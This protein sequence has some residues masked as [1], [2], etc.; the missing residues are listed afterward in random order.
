MKKIF[1]LGIIACSLLASDAVAQ[2]IY[3]FPSDEI[4][5][6]TQ[7]FNVLCMSRNGRYMGGMIPADWV[8]LYDNVTDKSII[9]DETYGAVGDGQGNSILGISD[10]G[11]GVG[12]DADG[13]IMCDMEGN[14]KLLDTGGKNYVFASANDITSDGNIAVGA[15]GT[16]W[17][18]IVPCYWE[19]GEMVLLPWP[20]TAQFGGLTGNQKISGCEARKVSADGSVIVGRFVA[21]PNTYPMIVWERQPDGTYEYV[22]VWDDMYEPTHEMVYDYE[23]GG[24]HLERG[25]NPYCWFQPLCISPDGTTIAMKI[26][27][28]TEQQNPPTVLGYY[29][30]P[31]RTLTLPTYSDGN[32]W[33]RYGDVDA[34]AMANDKTVV[35]MAGSV[36]FGDASPVVQKYGEAPQTLISLYPTLDLLVDYQTWANN[37]Y[38]YIVSGISADSNTLCG[39]SCQV[40]TFTNPG[41]TGESFTDLAYF[42][43]YI[44]NSPR[45]NGVDG[46][47]SD[48]NEFD[49]A[50]CEYYTLDG[51]RVANPDRGIY[52]QRSANGKARKVVL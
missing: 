52:I 27:R 51:R 31:T 25:D 12:F 46:V 41:G 4:V 44:E 14:Y 38:P 9:F 45:E 29:D 37:G 26:Q 42:G 17:Y 8:F 1:T 20:N 47:A 50:N 24:Y 18:S 39:Y 34:I 13:A 15:V 40:M 6:R 21:T 30:V 5:N 10:N 2:E 36:T 32:L 49:A 35:G 3:Q 19:N 43:F 28:N 22:R 7:G 48:N 11:I 23:E 16:G 33:Q